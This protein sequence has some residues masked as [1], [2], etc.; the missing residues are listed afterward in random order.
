MDDHKL[1]IGALKAPDGLHGSATGAQA[2][3]RCPVIDMARVK[4]AGTVIAL[5]PARRDWSD[6]LATMA[7]LEDLL[8]VMPGALLAFFFII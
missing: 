8:P 5:R 3:S 4:A 6:K 2:I 7:T 1:A